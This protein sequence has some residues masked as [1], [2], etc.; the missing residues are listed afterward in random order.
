MIESI[1]IDQTPDNPS[2]GPKN[3]TEPS[4]EIG[5]FYPGLCL[6]N[7]WGEL[8]RKPNPFSRSPGPETQYL[9][10]KRRMRRWS[11]LL[12]LRGKKITCVRN[13]ADTITYRSIE[14]FS[15]QE[16]SCLVV[17]LSK[18]QITTRVFQRWIGRTH[19]VERSHGLLCCTVHEKHLRRGTDKSWPTS[20]AHILASTEE[21]TEKCYLSF[22]IVFE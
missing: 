20:S 16:F 4:R 8:R 12:S 22:F 11:S 9:K 2:F 5:Y 1:S 14:R 17:V 18:F 7:F 13:E 21:V 6:T 15:S 19:T 10:D 3:F